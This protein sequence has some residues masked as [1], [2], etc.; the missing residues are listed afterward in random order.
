MRQAALL[1]ET[2]RTRLVIYHRPDDYC[3]R[4]ISEAGRQAALLEETLRTRQ[5]LEG[6]MVE[7]TRL[8]CSAQ[9]QIKEMSRGIGPKQDDARNMAAK[10]QVCLCISLGLRNV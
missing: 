3:Y 8:L 9:Q 10:L 6:E 1:V 4:V 7:L 2:V 5:E